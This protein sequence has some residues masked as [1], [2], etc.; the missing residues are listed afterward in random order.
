ALDMAKELAMVERSEKGRQARRYF[1]ECE[2]KLHERSQ[3]IVHHNMSIDG[4]YMTTIEN[5]CIAQLAPIKP[6]EY[7]VSVD[8]FAACIHESLTI[9]K[10]TLEGII[11]ACVSKMA[12][13]C[14]Y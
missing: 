3:G 12:K 4:R 8:R 1:I 11:N 7:V 14:N 10:A 2:R 5:G 6:G 13:R 9:K